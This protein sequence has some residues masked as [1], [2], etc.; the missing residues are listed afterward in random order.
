MNR[1]PLRP[2]LSCCAL[3]F[4]LSA[5]AEVD[6]DTSGPDTAKPPTAR[7]LT[8]DQ[9]LQS[10]PS[11]SPHALRD[12]LSQH[13]M[14]PSEATLTAD[15]LEAFLDGFEAEAVSTTSKRNVDHALEA[16]IAT[17][18]GRAPLIMPDGADY[19]E[20][21]QDPQN[22]I[23]RYK[24]LLGALLFHETGIGVLN[25]LP[26]GKKTYSC[27]SCHFADGGFQA[28][29]RQGL[30]E[31]G[32]GFFN[33]SPDFSYT[34]L[35][36]DVQPIRS[37]S[38]LNT[39]YQDLMLW[40]GQFGA[41]GD[42]ALHPDQFTPG[43]P[44]AINALGFQGLETQAIAAMAVHRMSIK[45]SQLDE[46][47]IY[48]ALFDLA[49]EALAPSSR[50]SDRNAAL[51]MAAYERVMLANRAPFQRWL[52]GDHRAMSRA[53]VRG[54]NVFF[55]Q[56]GDCA[57]C[58]TGPAL[59]SMTFYALGMNDLN[60]PDILGFTRPAIEDLGRGGFTRQDQD[61][62][63]FKT[64]QL[65]N[66]ADSPFYGH[67]GDFNSVREVLDY[68][69]LAVPDNAVVPATQLAAEFTPLGLSA[70][71]IND[72]EAFLEEGLYDPDL[73]RYEPAGLL[74]SGLCT[75]H[76]DALSR[77]ELGCSP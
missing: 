73:V 43:T 41:T 76:N 51:A 40:N 49:Y 77:Q 32:L 55:G 44:R 1:A 64:P 22:P 72:L 71:Q 60:G 39:A 63:K 24:V 25:R 66:L 18:G 50:I 19:T 48:G 2:L 36:F 27:A 68:K 3:L 70:S 26:Q 7:A 5:C 53:A 34:Q 10:A 54:A 11:F 15:R 8:V 17:R 13:G 4:A 58:H 6:S 37:P 74:P 47:P 20:L 57:A 75:P 59:N 14:S 16:T 35:Q 52:R 45:A 30:G 56:Q 23:N 28:N 69:N 29:R 33:R 62:Y 12:A 46:D 65:Y 9:A 42:N 31:G 61:L 67:G 38:T 21:P